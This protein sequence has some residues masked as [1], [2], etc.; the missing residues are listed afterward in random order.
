MYE[1]LIGFKYLL[2]DKVSKILESEHKN[3]LKSIIVIV[4]KQN[5]YFVCSSYLLN[6]VICFLTRRLRR[7]E[8]LEKSLTSVSKH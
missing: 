7:I 1:A 8:T 3:I 6:Y 5:T 2:C 4:E